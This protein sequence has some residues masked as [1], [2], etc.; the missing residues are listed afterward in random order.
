MLFFFSKINLHFLALKLLKKDKK[1]TPDSETYNCKFHVLSDS[2]VVLVSKDKE[3][4][5]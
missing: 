4:R 1:L 5:S 2:A 3:K